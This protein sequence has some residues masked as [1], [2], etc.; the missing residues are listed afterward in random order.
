MSRQL[1]LISLFAFMTATAVAQNTNSS[2]TAP[3]R[4]TGTN[5][6]KSADPPK[7]T[8]YSAARNNSDGGADLSSQSR[9]SLLPRLPGLTLCRQPLNDY[10]MESAKQ[11][12]RW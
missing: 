1:V 4:S 9:K 5:T 2:T 10:S 6:N 7:P 3:P 8:D 11:T 12:S